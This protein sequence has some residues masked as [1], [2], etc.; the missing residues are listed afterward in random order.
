MLPIDAGTVLLPIAR[1]SIEQA[2][3]EKYLTRESLPDWLVEKGACFVTLHKQQVL[4][5]CIGTVDAFRPLIDDVKTNAVSA[6]LRDPRFPSVR[7]EELN[8]IDIEVSVLSSPEPLLFKN[9]MDALA[10]LRSGVDGVVFEWRGSRSTFLP[11]VW[12]SLPDERE[13]LGHLKKKAGFSIDFWAEDINL[14]RYTVS[15]WAEVKS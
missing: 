3:G 4:R 15:K 9:E 12:E 1:A 11:Q 10:Q 14:S 8:E 2:L 13:F 7:Q 6:A 5:G